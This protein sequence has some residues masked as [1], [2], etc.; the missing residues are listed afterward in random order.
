[1]NPLR[2]MAVTHT[3][4]R[5][6]RV[7]KKEQDKKGERERKMERNEGSRSRDI[8]F[9]YFFRIELYVFGSP[10]RIPF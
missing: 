10:F 3:L 5:I 6:G 4:R 1:M 8:F 9:I 2:H 7:V